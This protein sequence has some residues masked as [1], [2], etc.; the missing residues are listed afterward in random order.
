MN[1]IKGE[2][3]VVSLCGGDASRL[4]FPYPKGLFN[5]MIEGQVNTLFGIYCERLRSLELL[6]EEIFSEGKKSRY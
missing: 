2:C 3:G 4:G 5:V 6:A 1:L